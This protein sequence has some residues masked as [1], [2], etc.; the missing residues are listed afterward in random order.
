MDS[1][2]KKILVIDDSKD[3]R[4]LILQVLARDDLEFYEAPGGRE[5]IQVA[6][7]RKPDVILLDMEM[8][9]VNGLSTCRALKSYPDTRHIPVIFLTANKHAPTIRAAMQAGGSDYVVKPFDP[10]SLMARIDKI[11]NQSKFD[12]SSVIKE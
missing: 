6:K 8:P 9:Q 2:K 11:L 10:G 12:P 1:E 4:D 3:T 5:G 7:L